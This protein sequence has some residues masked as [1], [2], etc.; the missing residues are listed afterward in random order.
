MERRGSYD[1]LDILGD[2]FVVIIKSMQ[3]PPPKFSGILTKRGHIIKNWK[4]RYFVLEKGKLGYFKDGDPSTSLGNHNGRTLQ[5]TFSLENVICG[6]RTASDPLKLYLVDLTTEKELYMRASNA[7]EAADWEENIKLHAEYAK[8]GYTASIATPKRRQST[9]STLSASTRALSSDDSSSMTDEGVGR[10][11]TRVLD[12]EYIEEK[13]DY[14]E[15]SAQLDTIEQ[16]INLAIQ[17]DTA[18]N[19]QLAASLSETAR[20]LK[21]LEAVCKKDM[22]NTLKEFNKTTVPL[23]KV[24]VKDLDLRIAALKKRIKTEQARG[25]AHLLALEEEM[26]GYVSQLD[27]IKCKLYFP[28]QIFSMGSGGVYVAFDDMW[29]EQLSGRFNIQLL[30]CASE[31]TAQ[32]VVILSGMTTDQGGI[33]TDGVTA[34]LLIDNFKLKGDSG[35]GVPPLSFEHLMLAVTFNATLVVTYHVDTKTWTSPSDQFQVNIVTF[36]G[37]FGLNRGVV[38]S[39]LSLAIP[40][41]RHLLLKN[42]PSEIGMLLRSLPTHTKVAGDFSVRGAHKNAAL[43]DG[44]HKSQALCSVLGMNA[45]QLQLFIL[46][47]KSMQRSTMLT[48]IL[49][50]VEYKRSLEQHE[51]WDLIVRLWDRAAVLYFAGLASSGGRTQWQSG[52]TQNVISFRQLMLGVEQVLRNPLHVSVQLT[53]LEGG[54]GLQSLNKYTRSFLERYMAEATRGRKKLSDAQL[55]SLSKVFNMLNLG[56]EAVEMVARSLDFLSL[57][58]GVRVSGGP[59]GNVR[60]HLRDI[61]TQTQMAIWTSLPSNTSMGYDSVIPMMINMQTRKSGS[62]DA[63]LFHLG[64]TDMLEA[65]RFADFMKKYT[66]GDKEPSRESTPSAG[67]MSKRA[68][69]LSDESALEQQQ[70]SCYEQYMMGVS[71]SDHDVE[72]LLRRSP[73][74]HEAQEMFRGRVVRPKVLFVVDGSESVSLQPGAPLFML[75]VGPTHA[76]N[77]VRSVSA[78]D[79]DFMDDSTEDEED[80]PGSITV[81]T[82]SKIRVQMQVPDVRVLIP[83]PVLL[84]FVNDHFRDYVRFSRYVATM[85][86]IAR[87]DV[88]QYMGLAHECVKFISR[89]L[90]VPNALELSVDLALDIRHSNAEGLEVWVK[91]PERGSDERENGPNEEE[92]TSEHPVVKL[93]ATIQIGDIVKD[94]LDLARAF[95][96][97]QSCAASTPGSSEEPCDIITPSIQYVVKVTCIRCLNLINVESILGGCRNDPYVILRVGAHSFRTTEKKGAGACCEWTIGND[98]CMDAICFVLMDSE[99]NSDGR[100]FDVEANV[101][102]WNKRTA[103]TRIGGGFDRVPVTTTVE[104]GTNFSFTIDLQSDKYLP[105]GVVEVQYELTH[106]PVCVA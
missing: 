69:R 56:N 100:T 22:D 3:S 31:H 6:G 91:P 50:L 93:D 10:S 1:I 37:P 94:L 98:A 75:Q 82:A 55:A 28:L 106:T 68:E 5:G 54:I 9:V 65:T 67:G 24:T 2:I 7:Q 14:K 15:P 61:D 52:V 76:A 104:L 40:I 20:D 17:I 19:T 26:D 90:L 96:E 77:C 66:P 92:C 34:R 78:M 13:L 57:S 33:A 81:Q 99:L 105:A 72:E 80:A 88:M 43:L 21:H 49:R 16:D 71:Q 12:F 27:Q 11:D 89:H 18:T 46:L 74:A 53:K 8:S 85:M 102:D 101:F 86:P 45:D 95:M 36:K 83:L 41:I 42:L 103:H 84:R 51:K 58:L 70:L 32:A 25:E 47:Q 39:V 87:E 4:L 62:I 79:H 73:G 38:S 23:Y 35:K 64:S 60:V 30:P 29:L 44:I 59:S 48:S 63:R 97:I